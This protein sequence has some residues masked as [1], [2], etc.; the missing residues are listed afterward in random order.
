MTS[1]TLNATS[2]RHK[3]TKL[4]Y[5]CLESSKLTPTDD[6]FLVTRTY[7]R[8]SE[9]LY[10][11]LFPSRRKKLFYLIKGARCNEATARRIRK[12]RLRPL[13]TFRYNGSNPSTRITKTG[14]VSSEDYDSMNG[15]FISTRNNSSTTATM[16]RTQVNTTGGPGRANRTG[17]P[18][19]KE[20]EQ[21]NP[22]IVAVAVIFFMI[23]QLPCL[24]H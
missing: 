21:S 2:C 3:L 20:G 9:Q 11:W 19:H 5:N 1:I 10:C 6:L 8:H 15:K 12:D 22:A 23:F 16:N 13:A 18:V 14:F 4:T 17:D 7:T 24:C